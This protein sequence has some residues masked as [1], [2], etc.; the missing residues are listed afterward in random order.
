MKADIIASE[1]SGNGDVITVQ[2]MS[3]Q[4]T[5]TMNAPSQSAVE[6]LS[7][8][9]KLFYRIPEVANVKV[10]LGGQVLLEA[11]ETVAQLGVFMLAPLGNTKLGFDPMTGQVISLEMQ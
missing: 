11:R 4:T 9:N 7:L 10:N 1:V 8:E 2:T 5:G 3:L 6:S